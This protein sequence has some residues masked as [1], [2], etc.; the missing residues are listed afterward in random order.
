[1]GIEPERFYYTWISASE[2][3]EMKQKVETFV[4]GLAKVG[5]FDRSVFM[6]LD[7]ELMNEIDGAKEGAEA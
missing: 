5:K 4:E 7:P 1:M 2:G 3:Q 6:M